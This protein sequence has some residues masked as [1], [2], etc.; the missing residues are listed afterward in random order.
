MSRQRFL[1]IG[2]QIQMMDYIRSWQQESELTVIAVLH[3]L[4]LAAQYC[5]RLMIVHEGRVTAIGTPEEIITSEQIAEVYGTE[6]IVLK[7][8]VSD[9]PQILLQPGK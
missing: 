7:H 1:D 6:P 8:P 3:D 9:V 4:N 5:T 2:Y